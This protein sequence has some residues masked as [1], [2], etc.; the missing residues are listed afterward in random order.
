MK[1]EHKSIYEERRFKDSLYGYSRFC[2]GGP[3]AVGRGWL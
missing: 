2:G 3:A 1:I